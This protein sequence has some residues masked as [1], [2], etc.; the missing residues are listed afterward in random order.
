MQLE[1]KL[2]LRDK[3]DGEVDGSMLLFSS[4]LSIFFLLSVLFFL[5]SVFFRVF[6]ICISVRSF[7]SLVR[8]CISLLEWLLK[9]EL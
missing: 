8:P 6:C 7:S 5:L 2:A 1:V 9:M 4:V 3:D